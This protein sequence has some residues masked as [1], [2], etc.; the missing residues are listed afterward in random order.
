MEAIQ[1]SFQAALLQMR[2]DVR[3]DIRHEMAAGLSALAGRVDQLER[4]SGIQNNQVVPK[5]EPS[6]YSA[7]HI[8]PP[9]L[10]V[11]PPPKPS[12]STGPEFN[13]TP[14]NESTYSSTPSQHVIIDSSGHEIEEEEEDGVE[15]AGPAKP[16]SI[17]VNHTTGAARLLLI[18]PIASICQNVMKDP[19]IKDQRY[20]MVIECAR[21]LLRLYGR[22]EGNESVPGYDKE[23]LVDHGETPGDTSSEPGSSPPAAGEEWGQLGGLTPPPTGPQ[24]MTRGPISI[25]GMPDFSRETVRD[26]ADSYMKHMNS[27]HPILVPRNMDALIETF[28]GS[29]PESRAKNKP[30]PPVGFVG[31]GA[32]RNPDSPGQ[33]RKRSPASIGVGDYADVPNFSDSKPGRPPRTIT[34]CLVLLVMAL[35]KICQHKGKIPDPSDPFGERHSDYAASPI[36]RNGHPISPVQSSPT[37]STPYGLAS[38]QDGARS[39]RASLDVSF[40]PRLKPRNIDFIPGLAYFALA[41]DILGNQNGGNSLQHVH[42]N[43]LAGLYHGQLGRVIESYGYISNACKSLQVILRP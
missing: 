37:M 34:T 36:I 35:G 14:T 3:Q 1:S 6:E 16:S 29:I 12:V 21:G 24:D 28:L 20:P 9:S 25:E 22:G 39:R 15:P 31:S 23:P 32:F 26:L 7:P 27:M 13:A 38:P 18:A 2:Q 10:P 41:T 8:Q 5:T 11:A 30:A 33:K 19:R 42:A 43:I 17:P 40:H 4:G